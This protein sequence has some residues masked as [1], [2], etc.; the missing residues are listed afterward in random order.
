MIVAKM[1]AYERLYKR[2]ESK[3][4]E[5]EVFKLVRAQERRTRDLNSIRCIKDEEGNV[6][7]E[8]IKVQER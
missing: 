4:G 5:H 7:I 6:L 1:N 3:E 8:D 2:L